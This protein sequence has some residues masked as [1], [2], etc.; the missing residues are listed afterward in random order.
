MATKKEWQPKPNMQR[1]AQALAAKLA[2]MID[3][4]HRELSPRLTAVESDNFPR[5]VLNYIAQ[6]Y[7]E[8]NV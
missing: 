5:L 4:E 7:N 2:E 6:E 8:L 1:R 3:K